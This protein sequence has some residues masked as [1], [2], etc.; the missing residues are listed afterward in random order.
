[1][2]GYAQE[3]D[4]YDI[5]SDGEEFNEDTLDDD[6]YEQLYAQ[7]PLLK[8]ELESYNDDIQE[9]D[10]K[11]AL[12]FNYYKI[13][14]AVE[15]LKDKYP[16][17]KKVN[18]KTAKKIQASFDE[19]SPDQKVLDAQSAAFEA[20]MGG[21]SIEEAKNQQEKKEKEVKK[22]VVIKQ[23]K[24]FKKID[25]DSKLK[26]S[27]NYQK[28]SKSFVVIGHVDAGKS[29]LLG[30]I[31]YDVGVVDAKQLNK[32][33]READKAG[34]GS[35]ALAWIMDQTTEERSRGVTVDIC[36]T[37]FETAKAK[38]TAIDA[39]GHKDFVPQMISG[40]TQ[41]NY[42]V[43]VIDSIN[44]EFESGFNMDGQTKEHTLL[45]RYLGVERIIV[46]VNKMDKEKWSQ[47][48]FKE[49]Q[50]Q[51]SEFLTNP[52]D[53]VAFKP[54]QIE[55]IPLSGL[56]GNN[57][58]KRDQSI[59]E[60]S[61][62]T[63]PTLIEYLDS[64]DIPKGQQIKSGE[65]FS[66]EE[67]KLTINDVFESSNS[68]FVVTGKIISGVVQPGETVNILPSNEFAQVQSITTSVSDQQNVD[69][70][71]QGEIAS[72]K[73]KSNQLKNTITSI[74][75]GDIISGLNSPIKSTD[76]LTCEV[77]LFQMSKPLLVGTPFVLFRN[78]FQ[79]S[80]RITKIIEI[81]SDGKK[82]K[83]K[84]HLVSRQVAIIEI[85]CER[86]L[87]VATYEQNEILGRVVLRREGLTIGAG[88]IVEV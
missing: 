57:L 85:Q 58:V 54:E 16:K 21:L 1:M 22:D 63:G 28:P 55:F 36:A 37:N 23:T 17:K 2:V 66:K 78:T 43:V 80:A 41:A 88:K 32:L 46:A 18:S 76:T 4:D 50:H 7:L 19:P 71:I 47:D 10:M 59:K 48:R 38:Y 20:N 24:P 65:E 45:A 25:L 62:Y 73:F 82:K 56:T 33:T 40:V 31:L 72:L 77:K 5:A 14:E 51:M 67:F 9:I 42:A 84:M 34:K 61:W 68:D 49:I 29:T 30:R 69:F 53:D 60:F 83:K 8:K 70:A 13:N 15:E 75:T 79:S 12:Y 3:E 74:A 35:F 52:E 86:P 11:E 26:S 81:V 87:P 6:E 39:P 64:L 44:G 27:D